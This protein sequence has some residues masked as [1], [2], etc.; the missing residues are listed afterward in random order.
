MQKEFAT[1][2]HLVKEMIIYMDIPLDIF[3]EVFMF[4]PLSLKTDLDASFLED[5]WNADSLNEAF[6]FASHYWSFLNPGV[7][8]FIVNEF[9][10]SEN[11]VP[12][13]EYLEKLYYF[14]K[15]VELEDF[16]HVAKFDDEKFSDDI[17]ALTLGSK[18]WKGKTLHDYDKFR[19]EL[20]S[21]QFYMLSG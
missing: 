19:I 5:I 9:G 14:K 10:I 18:E 20:S 15:K 21:K 1:L 11:D 4:L 7:L 13:K 6:S 17:Q 12:L 16:I 3:R 8:A 2:V